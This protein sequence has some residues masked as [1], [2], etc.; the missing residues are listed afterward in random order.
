MEVSRFD[1]KGVVRLRSASTGGGDA[2]KKQHL[3]KMWLPGRKKTKSL[4]N[5]ILKLKKIHFS[6]KKRKEISGCCRIPKTMN[7]FYMQDREK[8]I[9]WDFFPFQVIFG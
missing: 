6:K 4:A 7:S 3:L 9:S 5:H 2:C 8:M 1:W